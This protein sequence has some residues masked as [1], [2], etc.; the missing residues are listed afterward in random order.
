VGILK[1]QD[2]ALM[3]GLVC[4]WLSEASTSEDRLWARP[5]TNRPRGE[6]S[7]RPRLTS[8]HRGPVKRAHSWDWCDPGLDLR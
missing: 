8:E 4:G 7:D 1:T 5:P 6:G 2:L 3:L